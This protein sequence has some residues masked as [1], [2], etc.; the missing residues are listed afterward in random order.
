MPT[1]LEELRLDMSLTWSLEAIG[2]FHSI[3]N[4]L[5]KSKALR[6]FATSVSLIFADADLQT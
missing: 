4:F 6:R 1:K 5:A 3:R 2:G